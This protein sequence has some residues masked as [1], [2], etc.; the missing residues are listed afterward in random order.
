VS[1]CFNASPMRV[2]K[3]AKKI[4]LTKGLFA[5]VDDHWYEYLKKWNWSA[6]K[7][8][9]GNV[10]AARYATSTELRKGSSAIVFM[11]R[12]VNNTPQDADTDHV[13]GDTLN[14]TEGN[15]RSC[16]RLE[17]TWNRGATSRSKTGYKGVWGRKNRF[18]AAIS[19]RG[20][21]IN[22]GQFG[23]AEEAALAYDD[24]AKEHYGEFARLNFPD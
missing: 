21:R 14:N 1:F 6:R 3:M 4:E 10:Y 24:A 9:G 22:L 23:T 13:D 15:L 8:T 7:G 12:V 20:N 18:R 5:T 19:V 2:Y 17:N 16:T 11:H